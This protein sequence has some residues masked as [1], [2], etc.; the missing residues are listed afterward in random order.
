MIVVNTANDRLEFDSFEQAL[1][2][3]ERLAAAGES[4]SVDNG[5]FAGVYQSDDEGNLVET[6]DEEYSDWSVWVD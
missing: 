4:V 6:P 5:L 2:V 1:P 3:A